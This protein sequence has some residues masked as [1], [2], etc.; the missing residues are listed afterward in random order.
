[1]G[2]H[3]QGW[4]YLGFICPSELSNKNTFDHIVMKIV[5]KLLTLVGVLALFPGCNPEE[6]DL[7]DPSTLDQWTYFTISDGLPSDNITALFQDTEGMM[8]IGTDAGLSMFDGDTFTNYTISDGL[9]SNEIIAIA[10]DK[11][12]KIW[13]GSLNGLNL[14]LDGEWLYHRDFRGV[15]VNALMHLEHNIMVG[16]GGYGVYQVNSSTYGIAPFDVSDDCD[17][18]NIINALYFDSEENIWIGSFGGARRIKNQ[19]VVTFDKSGG[20]C[21]DLVSDFCEDSFGNIWVGCVEGT[22]IARISGNY[23]EQISFSNGSPQNFTRAIEMDK[24]DH[25]WIG[26]VLLGLYKY[27]GAFMGRVYEGVPGTTIREIL[28]DREG[29]LWIGTTTGLARYIVGVGK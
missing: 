9:L 4:G 24:Y 13:V 5:K 10:E 12:G 28:N 8:W 25:V 26:T 19:Q 6:K 7:I 21:G 22:S 1:V 2:L 20:L 15:E 27:D 16:T 29:A 14:L 11:D 17:P 3:C 23:V 18:C